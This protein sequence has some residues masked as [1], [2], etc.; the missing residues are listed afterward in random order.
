MNKM[1]IEEAENKVQDELKH[2]PFWDKFVETS[3]E[4]NADVFLV[5]GFIRDLLIGRKKNEHDMDFLVLGDG[6]DFAKLLSEKLSAGEINIFKTY[7]TA[8]FKFQNINLEFVG[9]RKES[10]NRESR[11]PI[12]EPG[13]FEDDIK[14]RDFTINSL[15]VSVGKSNFG[16][17]IDYFDG[18]SDLVK[19][20]IRTPLDPGITF[21]DDPLR[22][23][24][25]IRFATQ[26]NFTL[27]KETKQGIIE[28]KNRLTIITQERITDEFLKIMSAHKPSVGLILMYETG[29]LE[30]VFPEIAN[31]AGVEQRK[32]FH[33]KDVFLHTCE[34]VDNV[35]N[36]S[37]NLWL[38]IAAL[39]HDIAKPATKRFVDGI[40]WTFH[41]HE[42]IGARMVKPIFRKMKFPLTHASYVENLVRLHLRPIALVNENVT[43]SAIR[44]LIVK[45]GNDLDDLITLCRADITS[46]NMKKVARY[47]NNYNIV[48]EKVKEVEEK[49]KLRAFQSPVHGDEIMEICDLKPSRK[50]GEIKSAIEDA[51]LEGKIEN[52]YE[53]AK[54]YLLSIKDKFC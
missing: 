17:L 34:V 31:L 27:N 43:D 30:V 44:R 54:E 9:A 33:H 37:D 19:G 23:M 18:L 16:K 6:P 5:G 21:S 47:L 20:V 36:V 26:L 48:M 22:I 35:A 40:G 2:Y 7:G 25:A 24:R 42:E 8:H 53:A 28:N 29:V 46:K 13:T 32:D 52:T 50:V 39:L 51:I 38:R 1:K 3:T 4:L 14:R 11:N 10:Y 12:V 41:G 45:A 49:D 15:A